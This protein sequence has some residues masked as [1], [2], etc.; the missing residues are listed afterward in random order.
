MT[1][2][3]VLVGKIGPAFNGGEIRAQG[4]VSMPIHADNLR[5][6]TLG[7]GYVRAVR[8]YAL[9]AMINVIADNMAQHDAYR[10]DVANDGTFR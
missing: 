1:R 2:N 7:A 6:Q 3:L 8:T 4:E 5:C 9:S 10:F